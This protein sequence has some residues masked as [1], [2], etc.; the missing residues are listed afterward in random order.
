M[1]KICCVRLQWVF[2]LSTLLFLYF[3]D[4]LELVE[5]LLVYGGWCVEHHVATAVVLWERYAVAYAVEPC[6]EAYEAVEAKGE[7]SMRRRSVLEG[8]DK[9]AELRHGTLL[10]EAQYLEHLCLKGTV[11]DTQ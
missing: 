7:A 6:H 11:M 10:G 1:L 9:E 4:E 8:V 2:S 5:L 3:Y